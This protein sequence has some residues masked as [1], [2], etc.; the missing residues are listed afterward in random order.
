VG[1]HGVGPGVRR[2]LE[3]GACLGNGVERV[4]PIPRRTGEPIQPDDDQ[5]IAHFQAR[6]HLVASALRS[7][8]APDTRDRGGLNLAAPPSFSAMCYM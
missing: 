7:V 6:E 2:R 1:R 8:T 3:A 5:R 4:E